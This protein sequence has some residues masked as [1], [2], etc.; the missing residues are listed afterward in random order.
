MAH[1]INIDA[2]GNIV[3]KINFKAIT[4][5]LVVLALAVGAGFLPLDGLTTASR[6]CLMLFVG[7]AGFWVTEAIPPFAM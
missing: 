7:A 3:L 4:K 5:V 2:D 6:I 1:E